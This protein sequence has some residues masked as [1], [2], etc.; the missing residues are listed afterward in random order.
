MKVRCANCRQYKE[1]EYCVAFGL[2]WCCD[3][4]CR[5]EAIEKRRRGAGHRRRTDSD[6]VRRAPIVH[7]PNNIKRDIRE[8][9]G[10]R[11]R[12]CG[13]TRALHTHHIVYRSE[14]GSNAEQNLITLCLG[15]HDK[16][17]SRKH[18]WQPILIELQRLY[19]EEGLFLT[20]P[21]VE[22]RMPAEAG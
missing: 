1:K 21:E 7:R 13:T 16:V 20:V 15:H 10:N 9:D 18:H 2:G 14:H 4:N 6:D 19:Y 12:F 17:H 8:R 5:W 22:R 11:C 3:A